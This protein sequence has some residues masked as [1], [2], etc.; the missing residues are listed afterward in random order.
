MGEVERF[1]INLTHAKS[2]ASPEQSQSPPDR[3]GQNMLGQGLYGLFLRSV[4]QHGDLVALEV[5]GESFT[6]R[7]L[8]DLAEELAGAIHHAC[9]GTPSRVALLALRSPAAYIGY[10]AALR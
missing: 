5:A 7:R 8:H 10:L 2:T 6:Y 4:R 1:A 9:A 3:N